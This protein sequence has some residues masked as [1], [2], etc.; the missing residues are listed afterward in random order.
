MSNESGRGF[1]IVSALS[2]A[3]YRPANAARLGVAR[4]DAN[5]VATENS[6]P[7][8]VTSQ[9]GYP[10][11]IFVF[12][13]ERKVLYSSEKLARKFDEAIVLRRR[14]SLQV[15]QRSMAEATLEIVGVVVAFSDRFAQEGIHSSRWIGPST[16]ERLVARCGRP[17]VIWLKTHRMPPARQALPIKVVAVLPTIE[18][19]FTNKI[20]RS[21]AGDD[22]PLKLLANESPPSLQAQFVNALE[23]SPH[24]IPLAQPGHDRTDTRPWITLDRLGWVMMDCWPVLWCGNSSCGVPRFSTPMISRN[25]RIDKRMGHALWPG[26]A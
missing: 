20:V 15:E 26:V 9:L 23:R 18:A 16:S 7:P 22:E 11:E 6:T 2:T 5:L 10:F 17:D 25:C 12:D 13:S 3:G 4:W 19:A 8:P 24:E 14:A 1:A 21:S